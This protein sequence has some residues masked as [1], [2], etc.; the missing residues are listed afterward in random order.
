MNPPLDGDL[1]GETPLDLALRNARR[2]RT[3]RL[4]LGLGAIVLA[5]AAVAVFAGLSRGVRLLITPPDAA[6]TPAVTLRDGLGL[7]VGERVYTFS[8]RLHAIVEAPGFFAEEV[9]LTPAPGSNYVEVAL[10]ERPAELAL[11]TAPASVEAR[12]RL[13]G[14]ILGDGES[15][16]LSIEPGTHTVQVDSPFHDLAEQTLTLTRAEERAL[17]IALV[18]VQGGLSINSEP[19][20]AEVLV[21]GE[22]R[23][24]T[25]FK[26]AVS[27]GEYVIAVRQ[28][29]HADVVERARVTR[30]RPTLTRNYR[31]LP[32]PATLAISVSPAGGTLLIDGT[33]R[34]VASSPF[35]VA[36]SVAHTLVYSSPGYSTEA[37]T[38]TL[39]ADESRQLDLRLSAQFGE[40]EIVAEPPAEVF[41]DGRAEGGTPLVLDLP[42]LAHRIELRRS[43]YATVTRV[44]HPTPTA[45]QR[46][47]ATLLT[48]AQALSAEAAPRYRTVGGLEMRR[49]DPS[50]TFTMGAPASERGQRAN[51]YLREV[52]LT[53]PFYVSRTELTNAQFAQFRSSGKRNN[54]PV[55]EVTWTDA[56]RFCNWL[57]EREGLPPVYRFAGTRYLGAN[58][59]ADGYRLPTEA[60]WEWLARAAGRRQPARFTW[61]S[62]YEVPAQA[63]NFAD[64]TAAADSTVRGDLKFYLSQYTDGFARLAPV[65]SFAPH[66][67]GLQDLSG[68]VREWVHDF[69]DLNPP[70]EGIALDPS[71]PT[72]AGGGS[73]GH[74]IKGSGWRDGR[75]ETL[76][77][78]HRSAGGDAADDL[79]FRIAR[80]IY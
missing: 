17:A 4:L 8:S 52:R 78:A 13:D 69:D 27:G 48:Q 32:N 60:E 76:R 25:P 12:W 50:A 26:G 5:L 33:R 46:I 18:P 28:A 3:R 53:R 36:S 49:F 22:V 51:E 56:A 19:A 20:G 34:T 39:E 47:D 79:G 59:A 77:A 43:G 80:Y 24:V 55:S 75:V 61:G 54:L 1:S 42:A 72:R 37:H 21:D 74:V 66:R 57:S 6:A 29:G 23:G 31:L 62:E 9:A 58:L 41:V 71:G 64:E 10:R 14:E 30:D 65:G 44:V 38:L 70:R 7:V 40:V 63:G 35:Q 15:L 73:Q 16:A 11:S 67:S 68:N 45:P 2:Q